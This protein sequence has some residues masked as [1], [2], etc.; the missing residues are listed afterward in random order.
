MKKNTNFDQIHALNLAFAAREKVLMN[1]LAASRRRERGIFDQPAFIQK[2]TEQEKAEQASSYNEKEREL[3][4]EYAQREQ[5]LNQQLHSERE[6]LRRFEQERACRE[7]VLSEQTNHAQKK[8]E[9]LLHALAQRDKDLIVQVADKEKARQDIEALMRTLAQREKD[10]A[11]LESEI[12]SLHHAQQLLKQQLG[13]ELTAKQD[14]LNRLTHKYTEV[15]TRLK[16]QVI[17]EQE[18]GLILQQRLSDLENTLQVMRSSL[19]WRLASPLRKLGSL[20]KPQNDLVSPALVGKHTKKLTVNRVS[21]SQPIIVREA[22]KV[23]DRTTSLLPQNRNSNDTTVAPTL[24]DL[25]ALR[26]QPF[27][28]CAYRTI[29]GRAPDPDGFGFYLGRL[30]RGMPKLQILADLSLSPER[31]E[32]AAELPGLDI[33]IRRYRRMKLPWVGWL[34]KLLNS[35]K[36]NHPVERKLRGVETQLFSLRE[37]SNRR[38]DQIETALSALHHLATCHSLPQTQ[39]QKNVAPLDNAPEPLPAN[40][41]IWPFEPE[42]LRQLSPHAN[43]I[44]WQLKSVIDN[45]G[46]KV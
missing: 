32:Y 9:A 17:S 13:F 41:P 18:T 30:R 46:D 43:N 22:S 40:A 3:H 11:G 4:H 28:E 26:D 7:K 37:E 38:F 31:K 25:L 23:V 20:F 5:V 8:M 19:S 1:E 24:H 33:A 16:A 27:I 21:E 35:G 45:H 29:L 14:E 12:Q 2:A 34:F 10:V 6:A 36:G 44:Y 39:P 42:E 15:K